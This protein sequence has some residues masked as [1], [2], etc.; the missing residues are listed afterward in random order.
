MPYK[1]VGSKVS[2][3]KNSPLLKDCDCVDSVAHGSK[4]CNG[5]YVRHND[6][7]EGIAPPKLG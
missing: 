3:L 5:T 1:E 6:M 2:S 4:L 7:E